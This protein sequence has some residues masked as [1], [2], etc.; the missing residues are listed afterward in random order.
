MARRALRTGR[1]GLRRS[2]PGGGDCHSSGRCPTRCGVP[3]DLRR[4]ARRVR[5]RGHDVFVPRGTVPLRA[6]C[7]VLRG[8]HGSIEPAVVVALPPAPLR[9]LPRVGSPGWTVRRRGAG[10]PLRRVRD[11]PLHVRRRRL[12]HHGRQRSPTGIATGGFEGGLGVAGRGEH[13]PTALGPAGR[14]AVAT[15][16][17]ARPLRLFT[18]QLWRRAAAGHRAASRVRLCPV[19]PEILD[20]HRARGLGSLA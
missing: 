5:D 4:R 18:D 6:G 10:V 17:S 13:R 9:R 2:I 8:R 1:A 14:A 19:V 11:A 3:G 16:R 12:A 7:V 20:G 15:V